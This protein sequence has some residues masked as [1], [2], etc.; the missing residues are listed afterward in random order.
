MLLHILQAT[1]YYKQ[2]L[3]VLRNQ[4]SY[5]TCFTVLWASRPKPSIQ[6][7]GLY[8]KVSIMGNFLPSLSFFQLLMILSQRQDCTFILS[9]VH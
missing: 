8:L 4:K 5:V 2:L 1:V 6:Q 9:H 7:G 3:H